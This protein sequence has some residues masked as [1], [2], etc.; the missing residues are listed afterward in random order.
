MKKYMVLPSNSDFNRGDQ[1]LIWNTIVTAEK[2]GY[3]GEYYMLANDVRDTKQSQDR[4]IRISTP[5]LK[6]PSRKFKKNDNKTYG[7]KIKMKWGIVALFDLIKSLLLL[8]G[9]SRKITERF[10]SNEDKET[11]KVLRECDACFVKGGG[12]I[13]S[14]GKLTDSYTVY[15][16][17]YHIALAQQL[18]KPVYVMPNSFGP[19]KGFA[20]ERMVKRVLNNCK[21]VTV[22]ESISSKMLDEIE[23][24]H[25]N[26]PDLGFFLEKESRNSK[27]IL[28]LKNNFPGYKLVGITVRPYRFPSSTNPQEKYKKYIKDFTLFSKWLYNNNYLPV[29]VNQ[30]L[31][32]KTHESDRSAIDEIC[33][34]LSDHTYAIISN[35][36]YNCED[37]KEI[38]SMLDYVIGTRFHSVIFS[39]SEEIPS[40]A[41]TYGGNK[42]QGIMKDLGLEEFAIPM[43]EFDYE[44]VINMFNSLVI[45]NDQIIDK[46]KQAKTKND[47]EYSK[48][49]LELMRKV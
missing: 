18:D 9:V 45:N 27:E 1:A 16:S 26:F 10:L 36:N 39:L 3:K 49:V 4:G 5:I 22:R 47:E 23:I 17:L 46:L 21:L 15:Y 48:L 43:S 32:N 19:F 13:H 38:Y 33:N 6:H 28:E 42:G 8:S 37:L 25:Q 12:F 7:I 31:S 44:K 35:N 11:M 41:I 34:G 24:K 20:V 30:T 40:I 14:Y 29:F 2:A